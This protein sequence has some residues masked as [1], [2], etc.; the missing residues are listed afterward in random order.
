MEH[1]SKLLI[2]IV[3]GYGITIQAQSAI[4]TSGGYATGTGDTTD[5]FWGFKLWR[6][7]ILN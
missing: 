1:L 4:S 3:F 2:A 6:N 5:N 7:L